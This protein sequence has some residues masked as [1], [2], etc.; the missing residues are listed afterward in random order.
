M[1]HKGLKKLHSVKFYRV[2][3]NVSLS[4][5]GKGKQPVTNLKFEEHVIQRG[6][7]VITDESAVEKALCDAA[8][9][10]MDAAGITD[11]KKCSFDV[12]K[13]DYCNSGRS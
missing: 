12:C 7:K 13:T 4:F 11:G 1:L 2:K 3:K 5:K 10:L 9:A 8:K 6:C